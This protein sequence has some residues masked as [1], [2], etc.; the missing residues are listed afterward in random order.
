MVSVAVVEDFDEVKQLSLGLFPGGEKAAVDQPELVGAIEA[1]HGRVIAT[2][3]AAAHGGDETNG[4]KCSPEVGCGIL[5]AA[6]G[7]EDQ[8]G[9]GSAIQVVHRESR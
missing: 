7:M 2:V 5:D 4:L 3:A 8:A 9:Q 1:F 6:I